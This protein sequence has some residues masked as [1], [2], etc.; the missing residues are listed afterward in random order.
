MLSSA[1][2][3]RRAR[4]AAAALMVLLV[5]ACATSPGSRATLPSAYAVLL[6]VTNRGTADVVVYVVEAGYPKRLHRVAGLQREQLYVR[7]VSPLAEPMHL[8]LRS[9]GSDHTYTPELVWA[10]PGEV[11][12]L[13]IQNW[14]VLS[15]LAVRQGA[16]E[17]VP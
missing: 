14:L 13:T 12:E 1:P 6:N 5:S 17:R 11:V 10:R 3:V 16:S 2:A 4:S 7:R 8:I 15:E 9:V